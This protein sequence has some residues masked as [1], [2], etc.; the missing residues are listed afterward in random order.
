VL[1]WYLRENT[2]VSLR[3]VSEQLA[4]G[5]YT[6][7]TQAISRVHRRPGRKLKALKAKLI[8]ALSHH[9]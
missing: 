3:R 2:T 4:M 7:V 6:R 9:G 8:Q 5:H 1:A